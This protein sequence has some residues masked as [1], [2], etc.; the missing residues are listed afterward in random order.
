MKLCQRQFDL[1]FGDPRGVFEAILKWARMSK[2]PA[3]E[4]RKIRIWG[5]Y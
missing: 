1:D 2:T 3:A 4:T 5:F